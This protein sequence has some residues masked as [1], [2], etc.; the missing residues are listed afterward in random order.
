[1]FVGPWLIGFLFF[2]VYPFVSTFLL[3]FTDYSV[4]SAPV[5]IGTDNYIDLVND[6][7]FWIAISNTLFFV[8]FATPLTT[9]CACALALLLNF[10]IKGR[11]IF[12]VLFFLPSLVPLVCLAVLWR[13]LLNGEFGLV[14][15]LIDP[16]LGFINVVLG[17]QLRPPVWLE[18]SAFTKPGMILASLWGLGHAMVIYLA[19]LQEVPKELYEAAD[20]DGARFWRKLWHITLPVISPYILFNSVMGLIGSFQIFAVPYVMMDGRAGPDQ[21]M[22]FIATYIYDNAFNYWNMGYACAMALIF[23]LV[24]LALTMLVIKLG[25]KRVSY[26]S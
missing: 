8:I 13:W 7:S 16:F 19:G 1:M 25:E 6:E 9:I 2:A 12:R 24:V 11:S 21:S 14:N 4:L 10:N 20:L 26:D 22:L 3:S 18:D 17:T 15:Y 23:F 5:Y